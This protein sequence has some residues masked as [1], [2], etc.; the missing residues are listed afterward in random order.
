MRST[1]SQK[2][3]LISRASA[4]VMII[5]FS[6]NVYSAKTVLEIIDDKWLEVR[7]KNFRIITD[8]EQKH[9]QYFAEDLEQ[10]RSLFLQFS[11]VKMK[12]DIPPLKVFAFRKLST[13]KIF[14]LPKISAGTFLH[15]P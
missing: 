12:E 14:K 13:Y 10:F 15:R 6:Y 9:A 1:N 4:L 8:L 11:K 3:I 2:T 7:T 5:L